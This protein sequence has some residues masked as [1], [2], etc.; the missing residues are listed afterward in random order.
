MRRQ[1]AEECMS[2]TAQDLFQQVSGAFWDLL[3]QCRSSAAAELAGLGSAQ[4]FA[5]TVLDG[6]LLEAIRPDSISSADAAASA[7]L[8]ALKT[9]I[10]DPNDAGIPVTL[11]GFDPGNGQPRGLALAFSASAPPVTVVAALTGAGA[12]GIAFEIAAVGAGAFGP[13]T[14]SLSSGWSVAVSGDVSGGARLQ[15]PRGGPPQVLD[16]GAPIKVNW[17]LQRPDGGDP[18]V[19]GPASGP[20]LNLASIAVGAV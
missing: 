5:G 1:Y 16:A 3:N 8:N 9:L 7:L 20:S 18:I 11:H 14:L 10:P 4:G 12:A 6:R 17:T 13:V 15:L 2:T 19:L